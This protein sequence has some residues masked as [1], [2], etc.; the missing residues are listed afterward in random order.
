[1]SHWE[2]IFSPPLLFS[3][4]SEC[5]LTAGKGEG[6]TRKEREGGG[7]RVVDFGQEERGALVG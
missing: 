5:K 3:T 4:S 7:W 2:A 6:E 1:M